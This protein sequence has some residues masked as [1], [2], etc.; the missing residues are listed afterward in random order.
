MRGGGG[1][2]GGG[3]SGGSGGGGTVGGRDGSA[4]SLTLHCH[5]PE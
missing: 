2:G 3:R 5:K 4:I 1:E